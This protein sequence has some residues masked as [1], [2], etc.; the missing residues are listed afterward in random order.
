VVTCRNCGLGFDTKLHKECPRCGYW[1]DGQHP[2]SARKSKKLFAL[3][4]MV[5]VLFMIC[6]IGY[7]SQQKQ[8]EKVQ[9]EIL[10]TRQDYD[11]GLQY[12]KNSDFQKAASSL[13][14]FSKGN[15]FNEAGEYNDAKSLYFYA[16]ARYIEYMPGINYR[17]AYDMASQQ[18]DQI[19][20]NYN[21]QFAKDIKSFKERV[22]DRLETYKKTDADRV[23]E[24][25]NKIN[26]GDSDVKVTQIFGEPKKK[27][28]T[29]VGNK[30]TEQWVYSKNYI[31]IENG[32]VTGW[33]E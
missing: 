3:G 18:L 25:Q 11:Q 15:F 7:A 1:I 24:N 23:Q 29:V 27:N 32:R 8:K 14:R 16:S 12:L 22:N 31:Y 28:R 33:Q 26:V 10:Q 2:E 20:D 4:A 6:W 17:V 9:K 21:G 5:L 19:P 30:V 13:S